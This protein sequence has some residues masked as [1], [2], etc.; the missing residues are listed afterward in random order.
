MHMARVEQRQ[1]H[2][3][4][5]V[6]GLNNRCNAENKEKRE[7]KDVIVQEEMATQID[8]MGDETVAHD[9]VSSGVVAQMLLATSIPRPTSTTY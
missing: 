4:V 9:D 3:G 8:R 6:Q 5:V 1:Q 7:D 2:Q